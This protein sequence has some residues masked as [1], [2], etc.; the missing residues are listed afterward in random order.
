MSELR[1]YDDWHH[2]YDD[3]DSDLS[4][5]LRTV[6]THIRRALDERAGPVRVLSACAGDGRDIL[7][8]LG[9]RADAA[10]V[11]ATLIEVHPEIAER[12]RQAAADLASRVEVRQRDAGL[13][14][15]YLG[16]VPADLVLLVGILGNVTHDDLVRTIRTAPRLCVPGATLIW[17]R[18]RDIGDLNALVRSE[19]ASAGFAELHYDALDAGSLPAVGV[20]RYEGPPLPLVLGRR[21][22]TFTR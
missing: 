10:R 5:R 9:E 6:Q 22:F 8:V 19:F 14:D 1:D 11:N 20:V 4:W 16:A 17:T 15:A 3:P 21:I 2:R 7:G 13:S 18:A 12:G